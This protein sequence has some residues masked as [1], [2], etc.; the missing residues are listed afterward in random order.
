MSTPERQQDAASEKA[1]DG[2]NDQPDTALRNSKSDDSQSAPASVR[3]KRFQTQRR[4]RIP[5]LTPR[6]GMND[7]RMPNRRKRT[8][9]R[10][11]RKAANCLVKASFPTTYAM[12]QLARVAGD[13]R[14]RWRHVL[15]PGGIEDH[16]GEQH[17]SAAG[18]VRQPQR[19]ERS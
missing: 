7:G 13:C 18:F 16:A 5:T 11:K 12:P 10:P 15:D 19:P 6:E 8:S 4:S 2:A 9:G 3:A 17:H 14:A 1:G